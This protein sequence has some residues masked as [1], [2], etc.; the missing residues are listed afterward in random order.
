MVHKNPQAL[1]TTGR[2]LGVDVGSKT[3]G[4]AISDSR[5]IL[6]SPR[7]V[8]NRAGWDKDQTKLQE[9]ITQNNIVALVVGLPLTLQ[10][11]TSSSTDAATS[12]ADLAEKAFNLPVLLWD[13]RLT[14]QQAENALFEQRTAGSRQTRGSK[15]QIKPRLDSAAAVLIL[16]NVLDRLRP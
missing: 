11:T 5:Q 1:P 13:E 8:I 15:K 3:L 9:I 4:L 16:Q 7:P 10:N 6:A 2:L 12:F 14:T